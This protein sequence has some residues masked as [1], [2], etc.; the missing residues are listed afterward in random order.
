ML[1]DE[2]GEVF[3]ILC[4]STRNAVIA[5]HEVSRGTLDAS[6]VQ[7]LRWVLDQGLE[8]VGDAREIFLEHPA[9]VSD[10]RKYQTELA[11]P[12]RRVAKG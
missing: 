6:L 1:G 9:S 5:Y 3:G 8:I 2:P 7:L 12:I 4:L 10:P 11:I